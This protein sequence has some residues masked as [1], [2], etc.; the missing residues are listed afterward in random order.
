VSVSVYDPIVAPLPIP[1]QFSKPDWIVFIK[2]AY[3]VNG[4]E[5]CNMYSHEYRSIP[6]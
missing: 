3:Q 5:I 1:P 4:T 2:G 6:D